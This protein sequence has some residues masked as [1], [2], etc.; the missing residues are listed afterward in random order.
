MYVGHLVII[1]VDQ[2]FENIF[3]NLDYGADVSAD[4]AKDIFADEVSDVVANMKE[5][6]GFIRFGD[7]FIKISQIRGIKVCDMKDINDK[8][9]EK[10][11]EVTNE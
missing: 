7:K 8:E 3:I 11:K 5:E 9:V 2:T 6:D 4:E 1:Y 10:E